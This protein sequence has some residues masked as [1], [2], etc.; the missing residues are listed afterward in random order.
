[1]SNYNTVHAKMAKY[2][3]DNFQQNICILRQA[4]RSQMFELAKNSKN[5]VPASCN[6]GT[7]H[8]LVSLDFL[9]TWVKVLMLGVVIVTNF[10]KTKYDMCNCMC[11]LSC[12]VYCRGHI[13]YF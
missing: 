5:P 2:F 1:M 4:K 8:D 13:M 11:C 6:E 12:F 7:H 3:N 9:L 10:L